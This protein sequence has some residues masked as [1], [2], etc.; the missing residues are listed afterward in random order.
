M[1][2]IRE[3][4]VTTKPSEIE[5]VE[6]G[7]VVRFSYHNPCKLF[8]N[9]KRLYVFISA[10][11]KELEKNSEDRQLGHNK[12]WAKKFTFIMMSRNKVKL[13]LTEPISGHKEMILPQD[14]FVK[15]VK[16]M[17]EP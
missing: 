13:I 11:F 12:F 2:V 17:F 4:G 3:K 16:D 9:P 1:A 7:M 8:F 10:Y 5:I 6:D 14:A 15:E